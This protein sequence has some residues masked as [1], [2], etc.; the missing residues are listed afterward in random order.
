[1]RSGNYHDVVK[2]KQ[3]IFISAILGFLGV[4]LGAFGA[5]VL[6]ESLEAAGTIETWRTGVHYLQFQAVALLVLGCFLPASPLRAI[7]ILWVV[8][9]LLFS[10]SLLGLALEGP[11]WLGPITPLGGISLLAG[12]VWLAVVALR[13]KESPA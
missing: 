4:A 1:M 13:W 3:W 10:G 2:S 11:S 7:G 6:K 9:I 12:W 5:H 8:G